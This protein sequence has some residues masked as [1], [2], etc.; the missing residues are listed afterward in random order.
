[1]SKKENRGHRTPYAKFKRIMDEAAGNSTA[2]YQGHGRF[3]NTLSI[4]ELQEVSIYGIKMIA[5]VDGTSDAPQNTPSEIPD[6]CHPRDTPKVETPDCCPHDPD[7]KD[8]DDHHHHH[9]E[10]AETYT[11]GRGAASGLVKGLKGQ[12][13]YDDSQFPRLP[14]EGEAVPLRGIQFIE[15]WID[16]G[17]PEHHMPRHHDDDDGDGNDNAYDPLTDGEEAHPS[18]PHSNTFKYEAGSVL[19]RKNAQYLTDHEKEELRYA[20]QEIKN[21]DKFPLDKRSFNA[22]GKIHGDSCQHGWEQFLPW[23]RSF[24]Y[25]FEQL[26][27]DYAPGVALPYWDWT[28]PMYNKGIP[29]P[30]GMSGIIP[31]LYRCWI[32]SEN[33]TNLSQQG[34]D[35]TIT[36]AL[37]TLIGTEYSSGTE[38]IWK[39]QDLVSSTWPPGLTDAI[40]AQCSLNNSLFHKYRFPG[41]YYEKA[42]PTSSNSKYKYGADGRPIRIGGENPTHIFHHHYPRAEEIDQILQINNW[43]DFGGGHNANS[44]FGM[45]SQNPH[46]TGHIWL[47]GENPFADPSQPNSTNNIIYGDMF[48]DLVAF[49]DPMAWGH[50][51]NVDRLWAKWQTL[52]PNVNPDNLTDVMIPWHYTVQQLLST[53]KLGYEYVEDSKVWSTNNKTPI[54]KF[55]SEDTGIHQDVLS[56]HSKAEVRLHNLQRSGDSHFIR[57][58]LNS[59][60]ANADTPTIDND[61]YVGY[62]SRFG[63]GDCVGGPGHCEVPSPNK[64]NF[65]M[66][67]RHHNTPT[68]HP[69]D[70][71]ENVKKLIAKGATDIH[72]NV[73]ALNANGQLATGNS[74]LL[75]DGVS[76]NFIN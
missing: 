13:P 8:G 76:I 40:W 42:D 29:H 30:G 68:N 28:L 45:L 66:R 14:F 46:N 22:Y 58:F 27:Q 75:M 52:H 32:T 15:R 67:G 6:C 2:D 19:Q 65:D 64:R 34:Y 31:N 35:S 37:S 17:L 33:I 1:M 43:P 9:D 24:L 16:A 36:N 53:S 4:K 7:A 74:R 41:M 50:H 39:A 48:N 71:T 62:I 11:P 69:L 60:E 18:V 26:L 25:E 44:S 21:L 51:S 55:K 10:T 70:A 61:N 56:N 3:W 72:V 54:T 20:I 23:H 38:L 12:F 5:P 47:G 63:H 49:F 57:V 59:P 73:V